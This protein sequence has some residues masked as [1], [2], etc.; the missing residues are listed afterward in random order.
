MLFLERLR[1]RSSCGF[2][3]KIDEELIAG[4]CQNAM[5]VLLHQ[6]CDSHG[7]CFD[8]PFVSFDFAAALGDFSLEQRDLPQGPFKPCGEFDGGQSRLACPVNAGKGFQRQRRFYIRHGGR[9][10]VFEAPDPFVQT[11]KDHILFRTVAREVGDR[12]VIVRIVAPDG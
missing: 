1:V 11:L 12:E 5:L 6:L 8:L 7:V 9:L 3:D 4:R 10:I 2:G